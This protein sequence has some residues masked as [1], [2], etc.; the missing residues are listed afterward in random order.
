M[1]IKIP[2]KQILLFSAA[3]AGII[4]CITAQCI[5]LFGV[6]KI[7]KETPQSDSIAC[8]SPVENTEVITS[9]AIYRLYECGGKIG[10]YD[11][12]S[13]III[14][15]IDIFVLTLPKNDQLALKKGIEIHSFKELT[16]II[17]DFST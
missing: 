16:E 2:D 8:E 4:I 11:A 9:K 7:L 6:Q 1:K 12:Q 15:V 14:D 10:I 3:I 13:D 5:S 17:D